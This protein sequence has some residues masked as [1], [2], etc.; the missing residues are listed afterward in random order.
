MELYNSGSSVKE[1][2]ERE[3]V[4]ESSMSVK[5]FRRLL[6]EWRK[7]F[8]FGEEMLTSSNLGYK[9]AA[10]GATVQVGPTGRV[11]RA[12]VKQ[13]TDDQIAAFLD[14]VKTRVP[15]CEIQPKT[16]VDATGMLEIP[17]YDM[18]FGIADFQYYADVLE[19]ILG[20]VAR[21]H[22]DK[23]LVPV[24][25]DLFHNDSVV[26]GT[27]TKGTPIQKVDMEQ[28]E[29]DAEQFYFNLIDFALK[30]ANSVSVIYSPGN[31]DMT[32]GWMF[33]RILKHRYGDVVDD[34]INQRKAVLWN[35]C[36]IGITHGSKGS[37][38][39]AGLR[40]KFTAEFAKEYADADV[41]EIHCGHLHRE[42]SSRDEYGIQIRRLCTR[43]KDDSWT[44][45]EG[46]KS[47]KRFALF[48]WEPGK[49][50]SIHYIY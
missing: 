47:Q 10:H 4:G 42:D 12:W 25:Q 36:F 24:G 21:R 48:E 34:S 8:S 27:T 31:H 41:R 32:V 45:E 20:I 22:W 16:R 35:R 3:I 19:Q 26:S 7:Q 46:Y 17:L 5:S 6:F 14:A 28:A 11:E 23:I 13:H 2:Y 33:A 1:I 40:G 9:F 49:L 37:D 44:K 50:K 39:A 38:T 15:V 29:H 43:N 30:K 18:H